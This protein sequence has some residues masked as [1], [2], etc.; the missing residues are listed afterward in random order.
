MHWEQAL[1]D[2]NSLPE[3][4]TALGQN[5]REAGEIIPVTLTVVTIREHIVCS[6][7]HLP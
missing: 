1:T 7:H 6:A 3:A 5:N 4:N 2:Q